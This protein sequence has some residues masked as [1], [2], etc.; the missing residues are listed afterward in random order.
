M[1]KIFSKDKE[2]SL[3]EIIDICNKNK[4]ITIDCLKDEGMISVEKEGAD[5]L[6]EFLR[7]DDDVFNLS[8]QEVPKL[9]PNFK[10]V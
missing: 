2:Y 4:L 1:R 8:W 10:E 3:K 6:F 5:C 7:V 9:M